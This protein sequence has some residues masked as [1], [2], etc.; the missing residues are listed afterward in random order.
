MQNPEGNRRLRRP[1]R[2]MRTAASHA[3]DHVAALPTTCAHADA[4]SDAA[5]LATT[6]ERFRRR[7]EAVEVDIDDL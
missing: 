3:D 5:L 6:R 4:T 1:R 7:H 2:S